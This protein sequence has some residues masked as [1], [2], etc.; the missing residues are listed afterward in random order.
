MSPETIGWIGGLG[1]GAIGLLG[2][3]LGTYFSIKNTKTSAERSFVIKISIAIWA[4]VIVLVFLPLALA[5]AH[6]IPQWVC[7]ACV[8][9][10]F[11]LLLPIILWG[12][13]RQAELRKQ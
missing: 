4:A 3:A 1:G 11:V 6:L 8:A 12:N 2:G 5:I 9:V 7:W 10:F 13:R